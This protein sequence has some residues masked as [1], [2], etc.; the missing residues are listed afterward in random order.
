MLSLPGVEDQMA[1][2]LELSR[3]E[4]KSNPP[5]PKPS[6][7]NRAAPEPDR[8]RAATQPASTHRSFSS[9]F[10]SY[11][12]GSEE[13]EDDEDLQMALACSLSEMEAQQRAAATDLIAGALGG[14]GAK[15]Y[16]AA[17]HKQSR[18]VEITQG[19]VAGKEKV[20]SQERNEENRFR[21]NVG[22]GGKVEREV[23]KEKKELGN[24][25][26]EPGS[27]SSESPT[28]SSKTPL[29][30]EQ[31]FDCVVQDSDGGRAKKKKKCGCSIC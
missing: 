4:G 2:A 19:N 22:P 20:V 5:P 12:T 25:S 16:K 24:A 1:L 13:D 23:E 18:V 31:E 7:H 8:H 27:S 29:S 17:V 30:S 11:A 15:R 9:P 21:V 3:R 26:G 14:G 28:D 6:I 10:F